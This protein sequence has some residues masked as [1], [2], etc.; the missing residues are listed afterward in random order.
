MQIYKLLDLCLNNFNSTI[1]R[2]I[3]NEV[4]SL[5]T[6]G[7]FQFNHCTINSLSRSVAVVAL[8]DFNS[9]IV[10]LIGRMNT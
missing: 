10:R 1:V 2:L 8:V 7:I 3:A 5:D 4:N 6:S 9:T